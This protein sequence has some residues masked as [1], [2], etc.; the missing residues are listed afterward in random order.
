ME[1]DNPL[2]QIIEEFKKIPKFRLTVKI[3]ERHKEI[4]K[5]F[6]QHGMV[7]LPLEDRISRA[8][9][10]LDKIIYEEKDSMALEHYNMLKLCY[11]DKELCSHLS[12]IVKTMVKTNRRFTNTI[13]NEVSNL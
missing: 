5:K 12:K 13:L 9:N 3:G 1:F 4:V 2:L 7:Q 10:I 8:K 11:N 6:L